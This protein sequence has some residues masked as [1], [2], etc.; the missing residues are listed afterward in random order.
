MA[1]TKDLTHQQVVSAAVGLLDETGLP[2]FSV[3]TLADRLGVAAPAVRWHIGTR[4]RLLVDVVSVLLNEVELREPSELDWQDWLRA[5]ARSLRSTLQAHPRCAPVVRDLLSCSPRG[6]ELLAACYHVLGRAGYRGDQLLQVYNAYVGYIVG[7]NFVEITQRAATVNPVS[8]A[9][10]LARL[11][12][13]LRAHPSPYVQEFA[14]LEQDPSLAGRVEQLMT[15]SYDV[16]LDG[17]LAGL[18]RPEP[19]G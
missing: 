1:A 11:T 12:A 18:P 13:V 7:F 14:R 9:D 6:M 3:R 19:A 8:D 4:D 17:L 10:L 5:F 15:G 16:G 2:G